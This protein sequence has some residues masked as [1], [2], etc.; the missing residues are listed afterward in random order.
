MIDYPYSD[1]IEAVID[2]FEA[3]YEKEHT[4]SELESV[5]FYAQSE[6]EPDMFYAVISVSAYEARRN[7]LTEKMKTKFI[8]YA[9]RFDNGE[10]NSDMN[11]EDVPI[12]AKEID[13]VRS[14]INA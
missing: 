3:P 4:M 2:V 11:P 12:V 14:K 9:K 1:E 7:A 8:E 6:E 13:F 10:F 5:Y